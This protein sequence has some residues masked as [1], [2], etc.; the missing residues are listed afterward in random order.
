MRKKLYAILKI[1]VICGLIVCG[2]IFGVNLFCNANGNIGFGFYFYEVIPCALFAKVFGISSLDRY[3]DK[4]GFIFNILVSVFDGLTISLLFLVIGF[5]WQF[6]IFFVKDAA[7]NLK[8]N[9]EYK[10]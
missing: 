9:H 2:T 3:L 8:K 5:I 1:A 10:D 7:S 6:I 4:S